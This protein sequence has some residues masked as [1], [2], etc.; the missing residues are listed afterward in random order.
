L[1]NPF[2]PLERDFTGGHTRIALR[3]EADVTKNCRGTVF[4]DSNARMM[5]EKESDVKTE[6]GGYGRAERLKRS[7]Q[8]LRNAPP[9]MFFQNL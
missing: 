9:D 5:S 8:L 3:A 6:S 1:G 2:F 7:V 4:R